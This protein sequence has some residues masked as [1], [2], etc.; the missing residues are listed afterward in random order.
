MDMAAAPERARFRDVLG[1]AEFRI[2]LIAQAQSRMGDQL[3]RVALALLVYDRYESA[4]LT[5]LVYALTYLPPLLSAPFLTGLAD[6]YPRRTVMVV[7]DA[8]RALLV[9]LMVI[10]GLPLPVI[11]ALVVVLTCPQPLFSAARNAVIPAILTGDRF[12]VGM[13]IVNVTDFVSQLAGFTTGGVLVAF[14]GGPHVALAVDAVTYVISAVMVRLGTAPHRPADGDGASGAGRRLT[15]GLRVLAGDRRLGGLTGLIWLYGCYLAPVALAAPYAHQVGASQAVVG[16]L[17]A[18]DL[19]GAALG[20]LLVARFPPN[21][22][23]RAMVPLAIATGLPIAATALAPPVAVTVLLWACGGALSSYLTLA[24]VT[25]TSAIP[26]GLRG[27]VIGVAAAGL[28]TAQGLGVL[29]AGAFTEIL[30]PS[31]SIALCGLLG[32]AGATAISLSCGLAGPPRRA[33]APGPPGAARDAVRESRLGVQ[34]PHPRP[35][36]QA[37]GDNGGQLDRGDDGEGGPQSGGR[38][39]RQAGHDRVGEERQRQE[40]EPGDNPEHGPGVQHLP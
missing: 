28:Q 19:P 25:L 34:L 40:R 2:L 4:V 6:R 21:V 16:V 38:A 39:E 29:L 23:S 13:S 8:A 30:P 5:T 3:A 26:D 18:A 32:T 37:Q 27:R 9:A 35:G 1:V 14:L 15:A 17:I 11:A 20:G 24:Q 7:T 31:A 36:R 12:P 22:R 33:S 10:P